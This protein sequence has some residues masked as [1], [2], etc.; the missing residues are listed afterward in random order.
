VQCSAVQWVRIAIPCIIWNHETSMISSCVVASR[1][2]QLSSLG[3][4]YNSYS[5]GRVRSLLRTH[6]RPVLR[7]HGRPVLRTHGRPVLRTRRSP[8]PTENRTPKE[9]MRVKSYPTIALHQTYILM[10]SAI[11]YSS[12]LHQSVDGLDV[13]AFGS[14]L[15]LQLS[16]SD[17]AVSLQAMAKIKSTRYGSN[18]FKLFRSIMPLCSSCVDCSE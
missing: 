14:P 16:R 2:I 3:P 10:V 15:K 9:T 8:R 13:I 11:D 17:P 5:H 4:S 18:T 6:G 1:P 12:H 7:T